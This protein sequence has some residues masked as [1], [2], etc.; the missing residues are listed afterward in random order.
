MKVIPLVIGK[1]LLIP[2]IQHW[3]DHGWRAE[4]VIADDGPGD[5]IIGEFV[6]TRREADRTYAAAA[7]TLL[8]AIK[9]SNQ[10]KRTCEF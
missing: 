6:E 4:V 8:P 5:I 7:R 3:P 10:E 2:R 1:A 9:E